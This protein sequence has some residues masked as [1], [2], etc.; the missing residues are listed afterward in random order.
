MREHR[1]VRD[2]PPSRRPER[3]IEAENFH[4]P[5]PERLAEGGRAYTAL[6]PSE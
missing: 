2:T 6:S 5:L 3:G 4:A 1:S